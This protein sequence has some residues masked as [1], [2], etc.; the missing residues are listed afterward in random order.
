MNVAKQSV[1]D[2]SSQK[3]NESLTRSSAA[4]NWQHFGQVLKL[5]MVG[6]EVIFFGAHNC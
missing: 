5:S 4:G 3:I 2:I 6:Q 1:A